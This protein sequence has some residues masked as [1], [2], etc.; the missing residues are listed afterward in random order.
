MSK[1]S[2]NL[3]E[4]GIQSIEKQI[5]ERI[6]QIKR[7]YLIRYAFLT[8]GFVALTYLNNLTNDN[9][10]SVQ[11]K[12]IWF[13]ASLNH[14]KMIL[15]AISFID[16]AHLE[17][18]LLVDLYI[19][20]RIIISKAKLHYISENKSSIQEGIKAYLEVPKEQAL[21]IPKNSSLIFKIYPHLQE[22]K[23]KGRQYEVIF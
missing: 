1:S 6:K 13:K 16:E 20:K 14:Q 21:N 23:K 18:P 9:P 4:N 7:V 17:E 2:L 3:S 11:T 22:K 8:L 15:P 10:N 12:K 19:E 5:E